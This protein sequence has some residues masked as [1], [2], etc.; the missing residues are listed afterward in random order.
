MF[1]PPGFR[2]KYNNNTQQ[3]MTIILCIIPM[4]ALILTTLHSGGIL[5]VI[6]T[7]HGTVLVLK[8]PIDG[9]VNELNQSCGNFIR[10]RCHPLR[11]HEQFAQKI[12]GVDE[13]LA[14]PLDKPLKLE[15]D[16]LVYK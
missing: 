16:C 6:N 2:T 9:A 7:L 15:G 4:L 1:F 10:L 8:G 3:K 5:Q 12:L 13:K 11:R 14:K